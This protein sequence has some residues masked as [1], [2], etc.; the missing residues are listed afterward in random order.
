M[1]GW[2][3]S[4]FSTT[5]RVLV[6]IP[7]ADTFPNKEELDA[8]NAVT[9]SLDAKGFGKFVG[10]GGGFNQMDFEYEVADTEVAKQQIAAAMAEH[11]PGKQY[12]VKVE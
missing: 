6:S 12:D 5:P 9:D 1:L 2:L 10:A 4:L 7:V 8:R 3:K 11:L